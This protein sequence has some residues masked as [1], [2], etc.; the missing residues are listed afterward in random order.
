LAASTILASL[1]T[2]IERI[3][4]LLLPHDMLESKRAG[5][6]KGREGV[7]IPIRYEFIT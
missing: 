5:R 6:R 7:S 2:V 4:T 3:A 1:A